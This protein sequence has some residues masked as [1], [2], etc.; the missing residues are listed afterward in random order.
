DGLWAFDLARRSAHARHSTSRHQ[1]RLDR[2][3]LLDDGPLPSGGL[4]ESVGHLVRP[5]ET[6]TRAEGRPAQVVRLESRHQGARRAR[7]ELD[8]V[9]D[10]TG[11]LQA[12]RLMKA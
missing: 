2:S 4:R 3:V 1:E 11:A 8:D 10:A 7:L 5:G 12:D 6:V 9:I